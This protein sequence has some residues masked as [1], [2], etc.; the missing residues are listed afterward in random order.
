M[1]AT[2]HDGYINLATTANV[3]ILINRRH[4]QESVPMVTVKTESTCTKEVCQVTTKIVIK[5]G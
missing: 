2:R 4:G 1:P 5:N 3:T